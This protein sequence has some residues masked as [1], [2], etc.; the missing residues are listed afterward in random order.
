MGNFGYQVLG[1]GAFPSRGPGAYVPT[2]AALFDGS[3]D[4]LA[5]PFQENGNLLTFTFSCW[6]KRLSG[7]GAVQTV[8]GGLASDK[9]II[10]FDATDRLDV[11]N[12]NSGGSRNSQRITSSEYRDPS[13]WMHLVVQNDA[14]QS[15]AGDRMKLYVNGTQLTAFYGTANLNQNEAGLGNTATTHWFGQ[16]SSGGEDL[17]AM[18][19]EAIFIDGVAYNSSVFVENDSSFLIISGSLLLIT[20][21]YCQ[22]L[23]AK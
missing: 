10:Q 22:L 4:Y 3:A 23:S 18:I 7:F 20:E 6:I 5:V 21:K 13:S 8:F 1:F 14:T 9:F 16:N 17:N 15:T 12:E 2:H 19:A 11:V